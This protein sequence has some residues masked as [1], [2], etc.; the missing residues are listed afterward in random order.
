METDI[1]YKSCSIQ[2]EIKSEFQ[3][4]ELAYFLLIF[5]FF[6]CQLWENDESPAQQ[7][8]IVSIVL[9]I[10]AHINVQVDSAHRR[11]LCAHSDNM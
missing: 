1:L 10:R 4:R 11:S 8:H 3:V 7:Q 6:F 2:F 9:E 5:F